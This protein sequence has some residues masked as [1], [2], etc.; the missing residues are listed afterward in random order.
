MQL[1]LPVL[2]LGVFYFLMVR[3]QQQRVRTHNA[4]VASVD[5]GDEIVS[6][7]G[8]VGVVKG[9][10]DRDVQLEIAPGV[11]VTLAKGAIAQK[12]P[13]ESGPAEIEE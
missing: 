9:V 6:A 1:L 2:L 3:P 10:A 8:I 4:L 12:A 5:V 11:V 13:A 7:G